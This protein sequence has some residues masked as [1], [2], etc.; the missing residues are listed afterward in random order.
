MSPMLPF[1]EVSHLPSSSSFYSAATQ[2]LG[3]RFISAGNSSGSASITYGLVA[4]PPVPIFELRQVKATAGRPLKLSR[5]VFSAAS[6]EAV[7]DFQVRV[8]KVKEE[9]RKWGV[10]N[11]AQFHYSSEPEEPLAG[12]AAGKV[13]TRTESAK[14]PDKA[15]ETDIDGN[16]MEV[17]Y[18]P[19]AEYPQ[20]YG[21]SAIRKTQSSPGEISRILNWN[22]DIASS[23]PV[24]LAPLAPA[25]SSL[26]S[27][28]RPG[29][30]PADE[31]ASA[32][33]RTVTHTS[34]TLYEPSDP[35]SRQNTSGLLAPG[36]MVGAL[37]GAAAGA[38]IGAG[39]TYGVMRG[40]P[41]EIEE[42]AF[43]RGSTFPELYHDSRGRYSEEYERPVK[44]PQYRDEYTIVADRR[45]PPAI[46]TR[47]T[48]AAA[49][50]GRSREADDG[51][52]GRSRHSSRSKPPGIAGVRSHSEVSTSRKPLM[53]TDME[54]RSYFT[55]KHGDLE[56]VTQDH[57][58]HPSS[59]HSSRPKHSAAE[60]CSIR[61]SH[62][63]HVGA[64]GHSYMSARSQRATNTTR[65]PPLSGAQ[66]ELASRPVA[67]APSRPSAATIQDKPRRSNSYA[68]AREV[69]LPVSRSAS[70]IPARDV[71]LPASRSGMSYVPARH[72]PL[73]S[74]GAGGVHSEKWEDDLDSIAPD[75][76]ISCVGA[77]R[78]ERH[79]R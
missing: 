38:A 42:P 30:F 1:I 21:S 70:Y 28:R 54:H 18:V 63:Y 71:P 76:S 50:V 52:E 23:E 72:A 79:Y 49:P 25:S 7:K 16:I 44:E 11:Q 36:A 9:N 61:R 4:S 22:Y 41:Q 65:G 66:A 27:P 75:D 34:N 67:K 20:N 13:W 51:Y 74:G 17:A 55:A 26:V 59:R 78:S 29:R 46:L 10:G 14:L 60:P 12:T 77:R 64:D 43:Q 6:P 69:P 19:P 31:Q 56:D 53:L 47:Y 5:V 33:R 37:M 73:P 57:R 68:S 45:P 24:S 2:P 32:S 35:T 40:G 39:L 8:R 3:L 62:T 58:G 15:R 48:H